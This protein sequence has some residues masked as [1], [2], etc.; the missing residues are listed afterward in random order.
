MSNR[1]DPE[2]LSFA[3]DL[4][5]LRGGLVE[6][7][8]DRVL[9]LLPPA[10]AETLGL[11]EETPL[12]SE[13]APLL[14]GSPVLERL[15]AAATGQIPVVYGQ[16]EVP[17]LKKAGFGELIGQDLVFADGQVRAG[18]RAEARTTYLV[19]TC[20]YVALSDERKEGL[21][22]VAV[23]EGSGAVVEGLELA[24]AQAQPH[25]FPSGKVP[26]HFPV[27]L[28][29]AV[30]GAMGYARNGI[31]QEL[32]DFLSS[33]RRRL[34]RDVTN[35]REYYEAL[36]KEMEAS[37]SHPNLTE[38]QRHERQSKIADLPSEMARKVEDLKQK[39]QVDITITACAALRLL[40][41][42]AQVTLD[43]RFRK[44]TRSVRAIWNPLTR[45]LDPLVCERCHH[46]I[47]KIHPASTDHGIEL[48][49]FSCAQKR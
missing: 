1:S 11:P 28:E 12:G 31:E 29:H 6:C 23:H 32:A 8:P 21:V 47:R 34:H 20:R 5:E 42:I 14:Y 41:A 15:V 22:Q 2:L 39:Y 10:L 43:V 33:M 26:P 48:L 44:L 3:G 18:A 37:L 9:A 45:R 7:L 49:C 38:G 25:F 13:E 17:Y 24:W 40:V 36:K 46:T 4:I 27:K 35:T 19:L 16:I 30:S